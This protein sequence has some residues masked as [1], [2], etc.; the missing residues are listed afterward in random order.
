M[1]ILRDLFDACMEAGKVL[2][3]DEEFGLQV[4]QARARLVPMQIGKA[5]NLQEWIED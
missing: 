5:G 3:C 4:A 1:G 2:K